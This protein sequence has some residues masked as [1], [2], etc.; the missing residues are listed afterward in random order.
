MSRKPYDDDF[1]RM[2]VELNLSGTS[3]K[4]AGQDYGIDERTLGRWK[5]QYGKSEG[6]FDTKTVTGPEDKRIGGLEKELRDVKME[7]DILKKAVG[8]FSRSDG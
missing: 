1:K 4:R 5:K 6:N 7:R 2:P 3:R 8:I